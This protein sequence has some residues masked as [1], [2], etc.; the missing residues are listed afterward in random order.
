VLCNAAGCPLLVAAAVRGHGQ[1]TQHVV[2]ATGQRVSARQGCNKVGG[3][4][5]AVWE[6]AHAA[7]TP[8][9]QLLP[10]WMVLLRVHRKFD[11]VIQLLCR[12]VHQ[13]CV[14]L[15]S[16]TVHQKALHS[17]S[18]GPAA[19]R[20]SA[21][22]AAA[23]GGRILVVLFSVLFEMSISQP[24]QRRQRQQWR[25]LPTFAG[26]FSSGRRKY[27]APPLLSLRC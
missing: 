11:A 9:A 10:E 20:L 16:L 21:H 19:V 6:P 26:R 15:V 13:L 22:A 3:C 24:G 5:A 4:A 25:G 27:E 17:Y 8:G 12:Q 23:A 18:C 1:H 7:A 2:S 14:C